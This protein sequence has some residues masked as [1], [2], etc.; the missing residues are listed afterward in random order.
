MEQEKGELVCVF[1]AM[2]IE[3]AKY[4]QTYPELST[5]SEFEDISSKILC[6]MWWAYNPTSPIYIMKTGTT[7]DNSRE[8]AA[9]KEVFGDDI[10]PE[11]K[12]KLIEKDFNQKERIAIERMGK[13]KWD[14]R[15]RAKQMAD[16][17]FD[18]YEN[19]LN[20]PINDPIFLDAKG[21]VDV[22]N[23]LKIRNDIN[24]QLEDIIK[25]KELGFGVTS[26]KEEKKQKE[27]GDKFATEYLRSKKDKK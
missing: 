2:G 10:A 25:T 17:I 24:K 4:K 21:Q 6:F 19:L 20:K 26:T 9:I 14:A 18:D 22:S 1:S 15:Y 5:I 16:K 12:K 3:P 7:G 27:I 11:Y 23:Y 13:F 8:A